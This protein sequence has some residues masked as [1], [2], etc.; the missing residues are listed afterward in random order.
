MLAARHEWHDWIVEGSPVVSIVSQKLSKPLRD[1]PQGRLF[2]KSRPLGL[3]LPSS[4]H[5]PHPP[6]FGDPCKTLPLLFIPFI[7]F[8]PDKFFLFSSFPSSQLNS[9]S[10]L[11]FL[12][13]CQTLPLLFIP[14][15]PFIPV[16][17][18]LFSSFPSSLS[19]SSSFCK[20]RISHIV[21]IATLCYIS[22]IINLV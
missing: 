9:S 7:A 11:H 5:P 3:S 1:V 17:F 19:N 18:F 16:K 8:I 6:S 22:P 4:L 20:N 2:F 14:L 21:T 15:I 12:H 10:S 13:P